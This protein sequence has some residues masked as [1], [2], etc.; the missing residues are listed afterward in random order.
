M[1]EFKPGDIVNITVEG[2]SVVECKGGSL[3]YEYVLVPHDDEE[4][5][6]YAETSIRLS[7]AV[8]VERADPEWWPP[9]PGDVLRFEG[10][11]LFAVARGSNVTLVSA[12]WAEEGLDPQESWEHRHDLTLVNREY[13]S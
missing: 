4:E 2:A 13:P 8:T 6:V 5:V 10:R 11:R 12:F 9:Q 1:T 7:D 3:A